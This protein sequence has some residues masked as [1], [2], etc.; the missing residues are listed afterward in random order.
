MVDPRANLMVQGG[1]NSG[2]AIP[3]AGRPITMGRRPDNDVVVDDDT[4]SRRHALIIESPDG[5]VLRDLTSTNGTFVNKKKVGAIEHLLKHG[6]TIRLAGSQSTF[7]FRDE[8]K[9]TRTIEVE[10]PRTGAISLSNDVAPE[11]VS[12]ED[13]LSSKSGKAVE[14]MRFMDSRKGSAV[15]RDDIARHVWP[16]LAPS[17]STNDV[18]D[19]T[20]Q[21]LREELEEDAEKPMQLITVGEYGYLLL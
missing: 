5:Y 8:G 3:L 14:L 11:A 17:S 2:Q 9:A 7:V 4:V 13:T 1:P 16:E 6:D 21:Q 15:S 19:E 20:I 10:S 18:I 12:V